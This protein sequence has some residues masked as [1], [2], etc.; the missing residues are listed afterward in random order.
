MHTSSK[1]G[2]R[3]IVDY[4]QAQGVER[5]FCVPGESYL[6]VLDALYDSGIENTLCRQEGGAAMMA[7][8]WGKITGEPGVCLVTRGPGATKA[9]A[10]VHI[11]AQD[12]T[13]MLL[14]VGQINSAVRHR[15][16]FQELD[17]V[18]VFSSIAKWV[19]EIDST[20]R[21]PEFLSRAWHL[22]TSG[23][24]GPVVLALPEDTL[25]GVADLPPARRYRP[26]ETYPGGIEIDRLQK[27]LQNASQPIAILGGSR[28]SEHAVQQFTA[29]AER[30]GL[31]VATSFRRQMLF[32]HLHPNYAGDVG[33]G[34]NPKLRAR[35]QNADLLLLVGGRL[36]ELPSQDY[37]LLDIPYGQQLLVHVHPGAEELGKVYTPDLA[38][39]A[40]PSAFCD[41]LQSLTPTLNWQANADQAHKAYLQWSSLDNVN[42]NA[43]LMQGIMQHLIEVLPA[44]SILSNGAGNYTAWI[45]RFYPFRQFATQIAPTSG[46]MGYGL[47]AAIAAKLAKPDRPVIAFAG[48]GCFQMTFQEFGT[49]VQSGA[50]VI[51]LII[52]NGMYGTIR[53]HQEK[54]FPGRVSATELQNPDFA[55]WARSYGSYAATVTTCDEFKQ[56][57][58]VA[59]KSNTPALLHIKVDPQ[60]ITPTQLISEL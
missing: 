24:P 31:P 16:A 10:G 34:I 20:E 28:W 37:T 44:D 36:S 15:E 46:S 25:Q 32:D 2:G 17:Y 4:L 30:F 8:A 57:F 14:F 60:T 1:N 48:D 56:A 29:F 19:A 18:R 23:R 21:I 58:S 12:S 11:A 47:P 41:A 27:L 26:I 39:H 52:D 43:S 54:N 55:D 13:P 7:D 3:L 50:A 42:A 38:V 9:A 59:L 33:I 35:I 40:S 51:V 5:V 53:M 22:A 6:P 45:Q 49:A